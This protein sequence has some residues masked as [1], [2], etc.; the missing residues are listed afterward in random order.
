MRSNWIGIKIDRFLGKNK[1]KNVIY[2]IEIQNLN[3]IN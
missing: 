1:V 2:R 3:V